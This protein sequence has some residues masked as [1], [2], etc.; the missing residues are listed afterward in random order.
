MTYTDKHFG[1]N[2]LFFCTEDDSFYSYADMVEQVTD[3]ADYLG[4]SVD[5]FLRDAMDSGSLRSEEYGHEYLL[6]LAEN[7]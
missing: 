3:Y 7:E 1:T 4:V 5:D 6:S 2:T